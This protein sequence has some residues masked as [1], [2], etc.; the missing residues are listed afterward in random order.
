M[1]QG[2]LLAM[3]F[4]QVLRDRIAKAP[5][6]S[7]ERDILK[8]V[9]GELQLKA[10][11]GKVS[12]ETSHN[13]VKSMIK[14]NTEKVLAVLKLDDPRRAGIEEE[15]KVLQS[16]LPKYL[17]VDEAE[18]ALREATDPP[19]LVE[20]IQK[21]KSEGQATGVAMKYL[22]GHGMNVEGET[23]KTVVSKLRS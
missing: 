15:N 8:V 1:D 20:E 18:T 12:D 23:V 14:N 17:T 6:K 22:K 13:F 9:L 5:F 10:A 11:S 2:G 19:G 4:E 3:S 7:K 16:L 21:A